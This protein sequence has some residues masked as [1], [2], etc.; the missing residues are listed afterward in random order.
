MSSLMRRREQFKPLNSK[1]VAGLRVESHLE[2]VAPLTNGATER[3][4]KPILRDITT[5]ACDSGAM[6]SLAASGGFQPLRTP[7]PLAE[8]RSA[9]LEQPARAPRLLRHRSAVTDK[10]MQKDAEACNLTRPAPG[11][12]LR[13]LA[14]TAFPSRRVAIHRSADHLPLPIRTVPGFRNLLVARFN[15]PDQRRSEVVRFMPQDS[16]LGYTD[17]EGETE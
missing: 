12:S 14:A 11:R 8:S 6:R 10:A 17:R 7:P 16:S 9:D 2:V 4:T 3:A 15:G 1:P 5:H 13:I